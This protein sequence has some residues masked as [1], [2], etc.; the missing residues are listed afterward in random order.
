MSGG[1]AVSKDG[2]DMTNNAWSSGGG[3]VLCIGAR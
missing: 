2:L 3:Q 1:I